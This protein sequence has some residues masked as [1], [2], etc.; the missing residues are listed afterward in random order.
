MPGL[1][2][3]LVDGRGVDGRVLGWVEG[4][5]T[6]GREA[7]GLVLGREVEGRE[8]LGREVEGREMLGRE[9]EG[10]SLAFELVIGIRERLELGELGRCEDR[11]GVLRLEDRT[12]L[13]NDEEREEEVR[14]LPPRRVRA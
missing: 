14:L 3:G 8:M 9:V 4:R 10:F 12:L 6:L 7:E 11:E 5:E 1:V 2:L 13:L